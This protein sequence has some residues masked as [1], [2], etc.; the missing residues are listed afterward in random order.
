MDLIKGGKFNN[1][2][3][4]SLEQRKPGYRRIKE[5]GIGCFN[6]EEIKS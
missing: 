3:Q 5:G 1:L 6:R 4:K 2:N